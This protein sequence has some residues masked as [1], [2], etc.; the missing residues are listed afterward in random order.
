MK[1]TTTGSGLSSSPISTMKT[2][3]PPS[4]V[5]KQS[6]VSKEGVPITRKKQK[7]P[8]R[9][10]SHSA[11]TRIQPLYHAPP[12]P[13]HR[14]SP[15]PLDPPSFQLEGSPAPSLKVP[16]PKL[17]S[18]SQSAPTKVNNITMSSSFRDEDFMDIE[19]VDTPISS[20]PIFSILHRDTSSGLTST[21]HAKSG[22]GY[23]RGLRPEKPSFTSSS[24]L[25]SS[26]SSSFSSQTSSE[27]LQFKMESDLDTIKED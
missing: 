7:Q 27:D 22:Q 2:Q 12:P 4:T 8:R 18:L 19:K 13:T 11:P 10:A 23:A 14:P 9:P 15:S 20:S 25:S 24:T 21:S 17:S 3:S 6:R 5:L 1:K 16:K 26:P